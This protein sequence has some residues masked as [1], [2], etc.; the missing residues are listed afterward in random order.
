LKLLQVSVALFSGKVIILL[1]LYLAPSPM[2]QVKDSKTPGN[3]IRYFLISARGVIL[4]SNGG[5]TV[6]ER[7]IHPE[8][9]HDGNHPG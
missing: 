7:S 4:V 8:D 5:R 3:E 1:A 9:Q 6:R 2:V